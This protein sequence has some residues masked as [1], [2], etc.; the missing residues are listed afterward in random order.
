MNDDFID[1]EF[2]VVRAARPKREPILQPGALGGLLL[3]LAFLGLA[4]LARLYSLGD[5]PFTR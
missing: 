3:M 2:R 1:A 4:T 5:W